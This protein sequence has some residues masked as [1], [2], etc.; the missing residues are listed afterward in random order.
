MPR[1]AVLAVGFAGLLFLLP[2][3]AH[4]FCVND[5]PKRICLRGDNQP[6]IVSP[7]ERAIADRCY[8]PKLAKSNSKIWQEAWKPWLNSERVY[9]RECVRRLTKTIDD[10]PYTAPDNP[11]VNQ[12]ISLCEHLIKQD[13]ERVLGL[14]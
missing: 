5:P 4:A 8:D 6:Y 1:T 12:L 10:H 9:I 13:E 3:Q 2:S 7:E 14:H 11:C